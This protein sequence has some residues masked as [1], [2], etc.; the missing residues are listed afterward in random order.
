MAKFR[1]IRIHEHGGAEKLQIDKLTLHPLK[2]NE[3]RIKIHASALNRLDIWV[4]AGLPGWNLPLPLIPGSDGAG[5]IIEI[6]QNVQ[7]VSIGDKVVVQPAFGC[8]DCSFCQRGDEHYCS[9]FAVRGE[10]TNGTHT[11]MMQVRENQV[12]K[13]KNL[14]WTEAAAI[15]LTFITA[16]EMIEKSKLQK[17]EIVLIWAASSGVSAAAIQIAKWVGARVIAT[18]GSEKKLKFAKSIGADAVIHHY[19]ENILNKIKELTKNSG[20]N[21]VIDHVGEKTMPISFRSLAWGGRIVTCGSTTGAKTEINLRH[22]FFKQLSIIGST[23]GR[24]D[25]LKKIMKLAD[26]GV[27]R[28]VVSEVFPFSEI[29]KAHDTMEK[30][31]QIGKLVLTF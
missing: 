14:N 16:W 7:T 11:E 19:V 23:M 21:L 1:A 5:E 29:G 22:L 10:N 6:G 18:A 20:V 17:D 8:G 13:F 12:V 31:Q 3:V 9:K 2:S 24:P 28:G 26:E 25:S 4:R 15:P 30:S 27:F